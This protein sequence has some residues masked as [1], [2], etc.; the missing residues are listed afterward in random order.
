MQIDVLGRVQNTRLANKHGLNALFE[1]VVNSIGAVE[2]LANGDGLITVEIGRMPGFGELDQHGNTVTPIESFTVTDT[3]IGFTDENYKSFET[4]DSRLK[5]SRGGKGIGRLL[6]LK[7]FEYAEIDSTYLETGTWFRRHFEFRLTPAAIENA[8]VERLS[9]PQLSSQRSTAVRLRNFRDQYRIAA[10]KSADAI[11][12]HL[13]EHCL[14]YFLMKRMPRISLVDADLRIDLHRAFQELCNPQST[15]DAFH[16]GDNRF[17]ISHVLIRPVQDETHSVK[18]CAHNRVV[19]SLSLHSLIPHLDGAFQGEDGEESL[20]QG[21]V[22][23]SF[24][25]ERVDAERTDFSI[26]RRDEFA[27]RGGLAWEDV[28]E[29]VV[30]MA[31]KWL[32][33]RTEKQRVA[34]LER[35]REYVEAKAPR[36]R[37]LLKHR[38]AE[39]GDISGTVSDDRLEIELH[40]KLSDWRHEVHAIAQTRLKE[41]DEG[42]SDLQQFETQ[43]RAVI[44]D[45]Q[46]VTKS[47]LADYVQHRA[48]VLTFFS[49]LLGKQDDDRF[50]LESAV[51]G[52]FFPQ[53]NTSNDIDFEQHNLWIIDERLV[54]HRF[55]ASDLPL[56]SPEV[57]VDTESDDRPDI[58]LFKGPVAF[59]PQ[60]VRH[61]QSVVIVEFKRPERTEYSEDDNPISQVLGYAEAIRAG[62]AKRDDGSTIQVAAGMPFYC[63]IVASLTPGLRR[64]AAR[65]DFIAAPD[66]FGYFKYHSN[67]RAYIEIADYAKVLE[68]AKQRNRAFF[69]KLEIKVD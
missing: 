28:Q 9:S 10:P 2:E 35:V 4:L 21:Y 42:P 49:S 58:L 60:S 12:R 26:D 32:Q 16:V 43:F 8:Q 66:G 22:V 57:P 5:S 53:R 27:Y 59:T 47:E 62:R 61:P 34:S 55:L 46:E 11:A 69:D 1:A 51:H 40:R 52:L 30:D 15:A 56:S 33:P 44:G 41:T 36:Y 31:R 18:F 3:G 65:E 6:W 50:P 24:L 54:Y 17:E 20:Y 38:A 48:T 64:L 45:L 39:V 13:I 7:A 68:D 67:H 23:G 63:H 29:T 14:E 25:D 37:P 19:K